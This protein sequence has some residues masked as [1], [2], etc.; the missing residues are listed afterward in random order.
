MSFE[1]PITKKQTVKLLTIKDVLKRVPFCKRTLLTK[2]HTGKFPMGQKLR[3]HVTRSAL[4]W[5]EPVIDQWV[6]ENVGAE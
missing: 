5:G 1:E 2:M 4:V 3:P 6:K